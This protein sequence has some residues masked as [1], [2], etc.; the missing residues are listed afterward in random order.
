MI[1]LLDKNGNPLTLNIKSL[2]LAA[3]LGLGVFTVGASYPGLNP[4]GLIEVG[5]SS[6]Q[7]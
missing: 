5:C 6:E 7:E 1:Q 4:M 3:V 2:A